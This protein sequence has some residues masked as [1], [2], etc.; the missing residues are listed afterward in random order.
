MNH[1]EVDFLFGYSFGGAAVGEFLV[2]QRFKLR[3]ECCS[4]WLL[5][6]RQIKSVLLVQPY[7]DALWLERFASLPNPELR[8][9]DYPW[10]TFVTRNQGKGRMI[11]GTVAGGMNLVSNSC[12]GALFNHCKH[13]DTARLDV[14][15]ALGCSSGVGYVFL[16]RCGR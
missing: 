13:S 5:P 6:A 7:F 12:T 1:P 15:L 16:D 4:G 8:A 2:Q 3:S 14:A 9:D 10:I 11:S